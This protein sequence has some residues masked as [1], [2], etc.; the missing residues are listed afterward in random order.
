MGELQRANFE[1]SV[2]TFDILFKNDREMN[3]KAGFSEN[4]KSEKLRLNT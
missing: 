3:L 2:S 1:N 4:V